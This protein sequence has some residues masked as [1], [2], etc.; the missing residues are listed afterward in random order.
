MT[1]GR[2]KERVH[3]M[4]DSAFPPHLRRVKVHAPKPDGWFRSS[5]HLAYVRSLRCVATGGDKDVQAAHVRK[6]TDGAMG[7]KPSD[8][9]T[10]PLTE[11]QH[12]R[13][14]MIGEPA[15]YAE[16]GI[17][18]PILRALEIAMESVCERTRSA[19]L[20]EWRRRYQEAG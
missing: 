17:A 18:D 12:K 13:Q 16:L 14:H 10:L 2:R 7:Q 3:L 1:F 4:D 9:F 6:G 20:E 15:F 11:Y 8:Y 5:A 19:A